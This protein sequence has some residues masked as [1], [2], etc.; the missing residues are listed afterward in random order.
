[1]KDQAE[2]LRKIMS[3]LKKENKN[4]SSRK[5]NRKT[6]VIAITSGK[7]GVGKTNFTVNLAVSL[8]NLGNKVVVF[9]AD[10]GLANVDVLFGIMPKFTIADLLH[11]NKN[12]W[13]IIVDGPNNI[14]VISGGSGLKDLLEITETQLAKL[15]KELNQLQEFADYILIDTGAGLSSTVLSFVNSA[16][17]VIIVTTPEPT[18][19]TDAYAMIKT[20]AIK[21]KHKELNLVING[22]KNRIEAEQVYSRLNKVVDKFLKIDINNLGYVLKAK[23]VSESVIQQT[24]FTI[25]YP[26]SKVSKKVNQI[27]LDIAGK[28][29]KNKYDFRDFLDRFTSIFSKGGYM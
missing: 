27:A 1:M 15:V 17:E 5:K 12:I 20:L 16:D 26:N 19:L 3:K 24:P 6:R 25:M 8:S 21:G 10:I 7:G 14:K 22:V 4:Y 29:D 18:S 23:I 28:K 11:E 13:D 2:Q 9:D